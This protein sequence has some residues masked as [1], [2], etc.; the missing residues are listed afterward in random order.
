MDARKLAIFLVT[1]LACLFAACNSESVSL[2]P[3]HIEW[4]DKI[5]GGN[6]VRVENPNNTGVSVGLR[7]RVGGSG[8]DFY[9]PAHGT[10]SIYAPDG[11]YD[12][13]F[14]YSSDPSAL[15]QGD[16]FS[17][18]DNGVRIRLTKV[19]GGNYGLRRIK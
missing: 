10:G 15:Y 1:G 11:A 5:V 9:V 8:K 12:I 3:Y 6:E 19:V 7:A 18:A 16:G 17:L 4:S 2:P 13:Y 14:I